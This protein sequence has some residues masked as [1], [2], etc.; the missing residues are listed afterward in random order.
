[1][2]NHVQYNALS[3]GASFY[4]VFIFNGP[5]LDVKKSEQETNIEF[6]SC[7]YPKFSER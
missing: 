4:V 2:E 6:Q 1:M 3:S 7:I 5:K